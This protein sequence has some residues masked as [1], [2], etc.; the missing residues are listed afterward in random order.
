MYTK[1]HKN[2]YNLYTKSH[3]IVYKAGGKS[4]ANNGRN[5][6]AAAQA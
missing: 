3:K 6:I 2:V 5:S 4:E 1:K